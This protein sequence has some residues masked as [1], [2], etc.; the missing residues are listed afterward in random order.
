LTKPYV[1]IAFVVPLSEEFDR[2]EA[3][4]PAISED[5]DGMI[6]FKH[7][8][9]GNHELR[10][11]AILQDDMGKAAAT[12]AAEALLSRFDVGVLFV[13]GIAGGL[14]GD[15]ALGDVCFTGNVIDV[16]ENAKIS[17]S[18]SGKS[19]TEFNTQFYN[20][21]RRL[22]F[23]LKYVKLGSDVKTHFEDWQL[24][25]HYAARGLVPGEFVGR[26]D[27]NEVFGL[28]GIHDGSI[29]C[30]AVS[31]S[32]VYKSNLK[33]IDR[34]VLALETEAGGVFHSA[35]AYD[36]PAVAVRGVCD[37]ADKNKNKLEEQTEG[38]TREIA[39]NNAVS[40]FA[41]QLKNPQFLRFLADRR[42]AVV[43]GGTP[44]LVAACQDVVSSALEKVGGTIHQQ[45]TQLS[46]EYHGKPRGYR[47]P[48]PRVQASAANATVSPTILKREPIN[49][50]EAITSHRVLVLSVPRSYPDNSLP[51]VAAAE[52]SLIELDGKQAVPVVILGD[53]IKPPH[54]GF[55]EHAEVDLR[56]LEGS[57]RGRAII[58]IDQF[59]TNAK[60]RIDFL[61]KQIDEYPE[62]RFLIFNREDQSVASESELVLSTGAERF[63]VCE[64][65]F[66]EMS[67]FFQRSFSLPDQEASVVA[68]RLRNMFKKFD[69]NAH[70]TYFAGVAGEVLTSLLR[71]NRRAELL[72]LAVSG[73]LSFA[74]ASDK[75]D[76]KLSRTTREGF[77]K[78]LAF[79]LNVEKRA[80]SKAQLVEFAEAFADDNDYDIDSIEFIKTFQDRGLIHF[81]SGMVKISL[82]FISSYLLAAELADRPNEAKRYFDLDSED[83]D[84]VTFDIYAELGV[85]EEI[86]GAMQDGLA[87]AIRSL[88]SNA[89]QPHILLT[90][91][92]QPGLIKKQTRLKELEKKLERALDDVLNSRPNSAEKQQLLDVASLVEE[93]ARS[94]QE[95]ARRGGS[96]DAD[97]AVDRLVV[98]FRLWGVALVLLGAGAERLTKE[99]KRQI[100]SQVVRLTSILLDELFRTFPKVEFEKF[101]KEA[102]SD[103]HLREVFG[104]NQ[105]DDVPD[106]LR[107]FVS[108]IVDAYEFSLLGYPLRAMLGELGNVAGQAVLGRSVSN[109]EVDTPLEELIAK[110]W[111]AEID[112]SKGR[113][114]LIAAI[115]KMPVAPFLRVTLS[116]HFM[117]RVFWNHWE[118]SNRLALLDAA[119]ECLRPVYGPIDKGRVRRLIDA[120][121]KE[122]VPAE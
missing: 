70:P 71:A 2:L 37:Y 106:D 52:L 53:V 12:R 57:A 6:F 115:N 111:A 8:D 61:R 100:A 14:S 80:F 36:V 110:V 32:E 84:Y 92:I 63:D 24:T 5:L 97:D 62:A 56:A 113:S 76:V 55:A 9:I 74:V 28:P 4:F 107:E 59:P 102:Q 114:A 58:I 104:L 112:A 44:L 33:Q 18:A 31:K 34:K 95:E 30:G 35:A 51:W 86:I 3:R 122:V 93:G 1:D 121:E 21:D 42:Q 75:N 91:E 108:A 38:R 65:S 85:S 118:K 105:G 43:H 20:T 109:V 54:H 64:I 10:C 66:A 15:V 25:Q 94:A 23:A 47:L 40:F 7:L 87:E 72:Q 48:L 17:D 27:K 98:P 39:A 50:L 82:P 13:V 67:N 83:F 29:V 68:L 90:D 101:K 119:E 79:H 89:A 117:T 45:L 22:T 120:E 16:L 81:D 69:L 60:N 73:F 46:P 88:S 19:K 103:E 77:L 26:K 99:P 116:T 78:K 11:V 49:L 41:L 96:D